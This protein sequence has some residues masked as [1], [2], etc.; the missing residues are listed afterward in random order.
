MRFIF[1][2]DRAAEHQLNEAASYVTADQAV[3][4]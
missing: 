1:E 3:T 2:A 4:Q